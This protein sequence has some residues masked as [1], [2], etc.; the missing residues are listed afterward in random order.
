MNTQQKELF[1]ARAKM[2]KALAHPSR[3]LIVA[4]LA[5]GPLF[6]CEIR[7]MVGSRMSTVS[8]HLLVLKNA[9]ILRDEKRGLRVFY[10]L[11]CPCVLDFFACAEKVLSSNAQEQ[12]R[13]LKEK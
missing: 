4:E 5:K 1:K 10:S 3:L 6:V 8:R 7:A 12:M 2:I 9:G 11:R 13:I